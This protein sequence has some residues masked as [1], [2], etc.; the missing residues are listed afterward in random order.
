MLQSRFK[1]LRVENHCWYR[2][3]IMVISDCCVILHTVQVALSRMGV[4]G[5]E[6]EADEDIVTELLEE[7][8]HNVRLVQIAEE[9]QVAGPNDGWNGAQVD[10]AYIEETNEIIRDLLRCE[11]EHQKL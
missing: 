8:E 7:E 4:F 1:V 6:T 9:E 5:D 11:V 10:N 2:E 3:D